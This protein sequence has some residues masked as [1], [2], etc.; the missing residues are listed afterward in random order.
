VGDVEFGSLAFSSRFT[1]RCSFPSYI[2]SAAINDGY[3]QLLVILDLVQE[4][5]RVATGRLRNTRFLREPE[6]AA[7]PEADEA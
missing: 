5:P 2:R 4:T 6:E 7:L 1:W 3:L